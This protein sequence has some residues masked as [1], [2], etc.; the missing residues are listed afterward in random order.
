MV[1]GTSRR[2]I[3]VRSPDPRFFEQAVFFLREGALNQ[4]GISA[5]QILSEASNVAACYLRR[6]GRSP[7]PRLFLSPLFWMGVGSA[8]TGG[9]WALTGLF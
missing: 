4:E 8:I 5:D 9:I 6:N 2:V 1:K 3:V 7:R